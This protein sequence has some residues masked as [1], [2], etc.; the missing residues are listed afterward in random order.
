MKTTFKKLIAVM[1]AAVMAVALVPAIVSAAVDIGEAINI[2]VFWRN[3]QIPLP[4]GSYALS[5]EFGT[6]DAVSFSVLDNAASPD[7]ELCIAATALKPGESTLRIYGTYEPTG[8]SADQL[9]YLDKSGVLIDVVVNV[10]VD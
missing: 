3:T 1:M 4:E 2:P 5:A 8:L 10:F 7:C 9:K 6:A